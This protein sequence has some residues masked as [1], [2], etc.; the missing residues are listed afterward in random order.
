VLHSFIYFHGQ[1][2]KETSTEDVEAQAP[3]EAEVEPTQ[4]AHVA[5]IT[6]RITFSIIN[7]SPLRRVFCLLGAR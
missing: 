3:Q 1:S 5:E 2:Q 6:R 4:E 7:P